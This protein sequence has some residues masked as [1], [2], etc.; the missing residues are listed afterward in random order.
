M[1]TRQRKKSGA[2]PWNDSLS[3]TGCRF[4]ISRYDTTTRSTLPGE[5]ASSAERIESMAVLMVR[6]R[7]S[8]VRMTTTAIW[9][10]GLLDR[11]N[12]ETGKLSP[13]RTR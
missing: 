11:A 7:R 8:R 6:K 9:S 10:C 12:S 4:A 3:R 5:A 1:E 2:Q 13:Q